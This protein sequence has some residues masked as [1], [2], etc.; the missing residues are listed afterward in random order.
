METARG[1]RSML[2]IGIL[3]LLL[4]SSLGG[5][6]IARIFFPGEARAYGSK[7]VGA[8][9]WYFAEGYTGPGFEEWI[10]IFNPPKEFG[11]KGKVAMARVFYFG[12]K[13]LI[14]DTYIQLEPG[15]RKTIYVN[16][17]LEKYGYQGDVSVIVWAYENGTPIICERAM[18]YN[19]K[20]IITGG[21][22]VLGYQ[23]AEL[24]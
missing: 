13:G 22:Q 24:D 1:K 20:G 19:Y 9:R 5:A 10:L 3:A 11:G 7:G 23:E 4:A 14:G 16:Q 21:S 18:Y 12:N 8:L 6:M 15:Q 17:E 2:A